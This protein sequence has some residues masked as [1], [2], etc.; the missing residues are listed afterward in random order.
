MKS[1]KTFLIV[2]GSLLGSSLVASDRQDESAPPS[3]KMR[4]IDN[5]SHYFD[6]C[7]LSEMR[8]D[9]LPYELIAVMMSFLPRKD[10]ANIRLVSHMMKDILDGY[11]WPRQ[12]T[13][14]KG[15]RLS[16]SIDTIRFLPFRSL[17]LKF[18]RWEAEDIKYLALFTDLSTLDVRDNQIDDMGTEYLAK[19]TSLTTL[20]VS[21]NKVGA[22]G[23]ESLAKLTGLTMLN[24]GY[25]KIGTAG[26][27]ALVKLTN[28]TSLDVRQNKINKAGK[29]KLKKLARL[30]MSVNY[31]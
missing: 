11:I 1:L 27:E 25:N 31:Y 5:T 8:F 2:A 6:N 24:I 12:S 19:L 14:I 26:A 18:R 9:A 23:T 7:D 17:A 13:T 21:R 28:L 3:L 20:N 10:Q 30:G 16:S 29:R 4:K 15:E 22:A